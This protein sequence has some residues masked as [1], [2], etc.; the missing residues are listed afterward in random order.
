MD[1][2]YTSMDRVLILKIIAIMLYGIVSYTYFYNEN[3]LQNSIFIQEPHHYDD[4]MFMLTTLCLGVILSALIY[5]FAFYF[6]IHNRQY[7]FYSLAHFFVLFSL[8][9]LEALQIY[10][11]TE[12]Y[13]FKNFYF[14]DI[15]QALLL[16]FSLLFIKLF[17]KIKKISKIINIILTIIVFDLLLSTIVG[18]TVFTKFIPIPIWIAFILS[19]IY[20]YIEKKDAPFYFIITGWGIVALTLLLEVTYVINPHKVDFPFLHVA[21]ALE[22]MLLSFA[23]SFKFKLISDA[24]KIQQSLLLQQSR[25]A[26]MGE[27][28]ST[29]AHQ[30]RQPLNFLSYSLIYIKQQSS[31]KE[32]QQTVNDANKQLQYMSDTIENFSNFYNPSKEIKLFRI[33]ESCKNILKIA[34]PTLKPFNIKL[35]LQVLNEFNFLGNSNELEQVILNLI[36]NAKDIFLE[37]GI[38]NPKIKIIIDKPVLTIID[39]GG[40]VKKEY[41]DK[42]FE[43]YFT[44]KENN[45]GIGLYIAKTI[46]ETE[47]RGKLKLVSVEDESR[48]IIELS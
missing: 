16:I 24:Q 39:N 25:L 43:P 22:A 4:V 41:R 30:W 37:R 47:M 34:S 36:N 32:I 10:P 29:I 28:I 33:A 35:E 26:S 40:G 45:D 23:L 2:G 6:Y 18:H 8:I 7:L 12:I 44:T 11:F 19:E 15:S 14:L 31:N 13:G 17:F 1:I 21:F 38:K 42:I 5:N 3:F 27:M 46:V 48:F 20:I 9:N